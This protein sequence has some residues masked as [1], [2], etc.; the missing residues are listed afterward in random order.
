MEAPKNE[1]LQLA[2]KREQSENTKKSKKK[3]RQKKNIPV[4][5]ISQNWKKI[6]KQITA[7]NSK[8]KKP[9]EFKK[10][11]IRDVRPLSQ[12]IFDP[13]SYLYGGYFFLMKFY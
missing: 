2:G 13:P 9:N 7:E 5:N 4:A 11:K 8:E 6:Q 10:Q 3:H 1:N 12:Q